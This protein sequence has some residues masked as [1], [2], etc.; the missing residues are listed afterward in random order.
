MHVVYV[1]GGYPHP[2]GGGGAGTYVQLVGRELVHQGHQVT[3]V[4]SACP[5]CPPVA[6]DQGVRVLRPVLRGPF[7]WYA[8][9]APGLRTFALALRTLERGWHLYQFLEKLYRQAPIDVVESSEGGDF[10]HAVRPRF[11]YVAH[12]HGSRYTFLHQAGKLVGRSDWWDRRLGLWAID[13]AAWVVSPSQAMLDVVQREAGKSFRRAEVIPYPLDPRLLECP[14]GRVQHASGK[15]IVLFAA[16]N[17]PVK[18][19]DV[20]LRAIPLVHRQV[21]EVEFRLFGYQPTPSQRLPDGVN[22]FPFVPKSELLAQYHQADLVV[23][24]SR[25]D[26]SPNTVYEAMAAGKALVASRVGG[27][28]ELVVDGETG[29]LVPPGDAVALAEALSE[30]LSTHHRMSV[31]GEAGREQIQRIAGLEANIQRRL[32]IY[33]EVAQAN[34]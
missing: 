31:M 5:R 11:P 20:L 32:R 15:K 9:R 23:V 29:L 13:R 4:A 24:P 25:W 8:S 3:V 28:P 16:R 21:P 17:D 14:P 27:I 33:R 34:V 12:L 19:A 7:H 26:N 18:G 6:S 22:C 30:L 2:H 1:E 10:W